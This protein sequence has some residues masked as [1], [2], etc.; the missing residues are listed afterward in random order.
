[1]DDGADRTC[2]PPK[3]F[4]QRTTPM[5]KNHECKQIFPLRVAEVCAWYASTTPEMRKIKGA[6]R[7]EEQ[8]SAKKGKGAAVE[9]KGQAQA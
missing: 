7:L 6:E 4:N 9:M 3:Y 8:G 1:M 5:P 2:I